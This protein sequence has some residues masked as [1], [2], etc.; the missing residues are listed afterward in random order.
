MLDAWLYGMD[1]LISEP[2]GTCEVGEALTLLA[3]VE[4]LVVLTEVLVELVGVLVV[5]EG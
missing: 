2:V 4:L 3:V 5:W 1:V